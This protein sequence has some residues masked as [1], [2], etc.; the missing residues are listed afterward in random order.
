MSAGTLPKP[1]Y[2]A[3]NGV[4]APACSLAIKAPT[5]PLPAATGALA[6]RWLPAPVVLATEWLPA[7]GC[8]IFLTAC[9]APQPASTRPPSRTAAARAAVPRWPVIGLIALPSWAALRAG[10]GYRRE[11]DQGPRDVINAPYHPITLPRPG[12]GLRWAHAQTRITSVPRPAGRHRQ[13]AWHRSHCDLDEGEPLLRQL[14]RHA[15]PRGR[16]HLRP[17]R[18]AAEQQPGRSRE[19]GEGPPPQPAVQPVLPCEPDLERLA[20]AF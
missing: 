10:N 8:E 13:P 15:R 3:S 4:A 14:L 7:A 5:V 20:H 9:P 17:R 1:M 11:Y 18:H 19:P 12:A 6:A 16:F 2:V